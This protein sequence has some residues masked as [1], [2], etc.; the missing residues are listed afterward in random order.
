MPA[1]PAQPLR[2]IIARA[3]RELLSRPFRERHVLYILMMTRRRERARLW[4]SIASIVDYDKRN[5]ACAC[6]PGKELVR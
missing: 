4:R 2:G 3:A 6:V 5:D 1:A